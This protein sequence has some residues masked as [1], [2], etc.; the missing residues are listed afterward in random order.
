M[1]S[2]LSVKFTTL[3]KRGRAGLIAFLMGGDPD[4]KTTLG[5]MQAV[6]KAGADILEVGMPFS[7]PMADGPVIQAA[8]LRAL[9]SGTT[10]KG[11]LA[12]VRRFRDGNTTTPVILMGYY[13][14][15]YHYG[16]AKFCADARASGADGLILVDL[17]PEEEAEFR[18]L[19]EQAG[20]AL[21][22][23]VAPT[24]IGP[25]LPKLL[26]QL[27]GFVYYVSI[28]GITGARGAN[29]TSLKEQ[30]AAIK[31]KTRLPV[32]VGFGVKTPAQ[33]RKIAA[34]A[35]AVVVGSALVEVI[36]KARK[37]PAAAERFVRSLAKAISK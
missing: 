24:S 13:N 4:V 32:A 9:E 15:V 14:P 2:R 27:Q 17:P 33:A 23:L 19:A 3:R 8:G 6:A 21:I 29:I 37:K 7:D 34:F 5:L 22:R 35:D 25:R 31:S 1:I 11:I 18:P 12:A 30:V 16:A 20:L 26:M 28:A 10:L 36:A